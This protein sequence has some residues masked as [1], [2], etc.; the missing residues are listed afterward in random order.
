MTFF[1][2]VGREI[3]IVGCVNKGTNIDAHDKVVE[4]GK[5][6]RLV[7]A[8]SYLKKADFASCTNFE[9]EIASE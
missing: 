6:D 7:N 4:L 5:N 9:F 3:L 2:E 1:D 8:R